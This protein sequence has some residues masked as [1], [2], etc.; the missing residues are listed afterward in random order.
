MM[1]IIKMMIVLMIMIILCSLASELSR[2]VCTLEDVVITF[3]CEGEVPIFFEMSDVAD[4]KH[5]VC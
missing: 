4:E 3:L 1:M 2:V 5:I